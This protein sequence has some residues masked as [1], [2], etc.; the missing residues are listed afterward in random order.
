MEKAPDIC[1]YFH[2]WHWASPSH[3]ALCEILSQNITNPIF[4]DNDCKT[5]YKTRHKEVK[6]YQPDAAICDFR[7]AI[8]NYHE[9]RF[10]R[11]FM[12]PSLALREAIAIDIV[13]KLGIPAVEVISY[14]EIRKRLWLRQAY[15]VTRFEENTS[16]LQDFAY[17]HSLEQQREKLLSLLQ[18]N[19]VFLARLHNAGYMH[20]GSFAKNFIWRTNADNSTELIWLDLATVKKTNWLNRGK[21][22]RLDVTAMLDCFKLTQEELD[23]LADIYNKN[24]QTHIRIEKKEGSEH[25]FCICRLK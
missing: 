21:S 12:R 17:G 13:R 8:K 19:M 25:N 24:C 22:I 5:F 9:K 14:G 23:S 20:G 6:I 18:K 15:F 3:A 16:S 4:W 1:S 11:Y 10:W 2:S 7:V